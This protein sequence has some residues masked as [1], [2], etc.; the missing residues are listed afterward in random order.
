VEVAESLPGL[1]RLSFVGRGTHEFNLQLSEIKSGK[2][3]EGLDR[4]RWS[5]SGNVYFWLHAIVL[6]QAFADFLLHSGPN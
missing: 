4:T 2:S 1:V 5:I 3:L 6:R